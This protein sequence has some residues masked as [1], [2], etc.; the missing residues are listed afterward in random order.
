MC[1]RREGCGVSDGVERCGVGDWRE[2][3]GV[4]DGVERC[5]V[6]DGVERCGVGDGRELYRSRD[7]VWR[8]RTVWTLWGDRA[9]VV[10]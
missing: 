10:E 5:G 7:W 9:F 6:G 1:S 2:W 8:T 4:S 3:C